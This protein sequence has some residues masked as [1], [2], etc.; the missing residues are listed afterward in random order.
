VPV[1]Q[2]TARVTTE[3]SSLAGRGMIAG[4]LTAAV[5]LG[6]GQLI[7]GFTGPEGSPVVA[8]GSLSIDFTPAPVKDFAIKTFGSHDKLVL[9]TGIVVLLAMFAAWIGTL[10]VRRFRRGLE[11][12]AIFAGIGLLATVTRP[13]FTLADTLPTVLGTVTA[14][15]SLYYLVSAA[16]SAELAP[17]R[18][19]VP[20]AGP[21]GPPARPAGPPA[22]PP[23]RVPA[24]QPPQPDRRRFIVT[25]AAVAGGAAVAGLAG[26]KLAEDASVSRERATIRV[27]VADTPAPELPSG[28]HFDIPGLS[29]FITPNKSF[30]RVDTAI[31]L[32][33]VPATSW[34]LKIHGMVERELEISFKELLKQPLVEDYITLTCVSNEVGGPYVGNAKWLG[35]S[36]PRLLRR[37]GIKAGADQIVA[38]SADGFTSGTPIQAVMDGRDAL[39][40]I[41]MNGTPLPVAHGFPVRMVVPG[42]YGYV[43]AC[44]WITDIEVTTFAQN[45][46]Y[47]TTRGWDQQ[48][49]IKTESRIDTPTGLTT[50]NPGKVAVAGVAWAQHRGIEAVEA[51]ADNG[52][53]H[54]AR[55]ATVP[56]IDTWRQWVWEWDAT[57]GRHLI[58]VR[59]TDKTGYTQTAVEA[60]PAPNGASGYPGVEVTING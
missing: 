3:H 46:A 37:A 6:V 49:P 59:A 56:G 50:Q 43:S 7:A 57:P 10:A 32:P 5:S 28:T 40:A 36:L 29:S 47:W 58:Q 42:L 54:E 9:V 25:S 51:R 23:A 14:V 19:A 20:P 55:L 11:G 39:L 22:G 44:K 4:I 45:H 34:S 8:V 15:I 48:A 2:R 30:Y 12:L 18:P 17:A 38:T 41:A 52:P 26:R 33:E 1:W 31:V 53:W 13:G 21:A 24:G 27:P 16:G 35:A 60:P